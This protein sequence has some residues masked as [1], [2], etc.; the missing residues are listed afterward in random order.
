MAWNASIVSLTHWGRDKM[1][2]IS[3]TTF[4]NAFSWMKMYEFRLRFHQSL[5]LRF[6]LTIFQLRFRY[7]LGANQATSHYLNEWW[8]SL[9]THM[10][11]TQ[12]QWVKPCVRNQML[13][14]ITWSRMVS[15]LMAKSML[16]GLLSVKKCGNCGGSVIFVFLVWHIWFGCDE[17]MCESHNCFQTNCYFHCLGEE[18]IEI[19]V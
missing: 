14:Q 16:W 7:W 18:L 1:A 5:L 9:Q 19:E 11:I 17:L 2:A 10:C 13:K 12:P 3:Q 8:P 4:S 15:D 6:E